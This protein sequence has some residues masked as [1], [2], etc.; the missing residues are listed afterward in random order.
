MS[1]K[2]EPAAAD[3][4]IRF[5]VATRT[6]EV[7]VRPKLFVEFPAVDTK[8][9]SIVDI[10][11]KMPFEKGL[12]WDG[13]HHPNKVVLVPWH[14]DRWEAGLVRIEEVADEAVDEGREVS[15][16]KGRA[17]YQEGG[18]GNRLLWETR[19]QFDCFMMF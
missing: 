3:K 16:Y 2:F 14:E 7:F 17:D 9:D 12:E 5:V 1:P 18:H 13:C 6:G 11:G 15:C 8:Y 4:H 19:A 10:F